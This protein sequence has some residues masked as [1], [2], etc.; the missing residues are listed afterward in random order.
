MNKEGKEDVIIYCYKFLNLY[1]KWY[2]LEVNI[3]TV[4]CVE[5]LLRKW[6]QNKGIK[7]KFTFH[8]KEGRRRGQMKSKHMG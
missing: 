8:A 6:D 2:N 4:N 5:Q 7:L 3:N 1:L